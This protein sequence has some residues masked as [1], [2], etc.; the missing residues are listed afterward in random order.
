M[1]GMFRREPDIPLDDLARIS[2]PTLV[3][4]GDDDLIS[5]EH[6]L[7]LFRGVPNSELA[8]V[9]G[10]SHMLLMEKP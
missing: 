2:V 8:I 10:T 1:T 6:T 3:L 9:P 5:L 4:L 7:A